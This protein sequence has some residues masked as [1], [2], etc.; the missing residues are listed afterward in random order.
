MRRHKS[1][2]SALEA[3]EVEVLWEGTWCFGTLHEWRPIEPDRWEGWVRFRGA[4]GENRIGV[5][6]Q[7]L[8]RQAMPLAPPA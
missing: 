6:D 8:I 4:P 2:R 1:Y 3:P 7:D 5:F